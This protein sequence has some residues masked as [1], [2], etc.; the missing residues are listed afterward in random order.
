MKHLKIYRAIRLIHRTGSIRRAAMELAISPSALNRSIQAFEDEL[1]FKVFERV[2]SGVTLSDAGELL[3]DVID[4][5]V[6]EFG[7][8]RRQLGTLRDGETGEL[9]ISIGSDVASG[10]MLRTLA[11][12]EQRFPGVSVE[13]TYDDT[14]ESL[15]DRRVHLAI[16]TNPVTDDAVEVVH[17]GECRI[18]AWVGITEAAHPAGIWDLADLRVILPAE[19]TGSRIAISHILRRKR[20]QFWSTSSMPAAQVVERLR[21]SG[22]VAIFP[23]I[24]A[25]THGI[26]DA[27]RRLPFDLGT[28]QCCALRKASAP[29]TRPAQAYLAIL[30]KRLENI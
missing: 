10:M 1:S 11:E 26:T 28:I 30:Q 24:I 13:I 25:D 19:G 12:M 21:A 4:R 20:L 17:A 22:G 29:L 15:R 8:L 5:H 2:P 6:V 16:L 9:R 23:E 18:A 14:V 7:E 3:L 27:A